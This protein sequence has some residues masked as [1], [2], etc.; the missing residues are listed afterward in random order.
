MALK[1]RQV[2]GAFQPLLYA[3]IGALHHSVFALFDF[4]HINMDRAPGDHAV[5]V[6]SSRDMRRAR[7]CDQRLGRNA[8]C[9]DAGAAEA[10][11]LDDRHLHSCACQP[12]REGWPGLPSADNYRVICSCHWFTSPIW[13]LPNGLPDTRG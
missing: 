9:V 8:A 4:L 11:A 1:D 6:G 5:L 3:F 7:A 10:L 12:N 13:W 2:L